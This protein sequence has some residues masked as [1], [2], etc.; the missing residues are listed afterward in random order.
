MIEKLN[1]EG[2]GVQRESW[3]SIALLGTNWKYDALKQYW[4]GC[5]IS[6]YLIHKIHAIRLAS[7][8]GLPSTW[9]CG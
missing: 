2:N 5:W 3:P 7:F 6:E 9:I 4:T 1:L 8:Y